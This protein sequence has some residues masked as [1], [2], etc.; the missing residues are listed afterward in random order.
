MYFAFKL[1][2]EGYRPREVLLTRE[3]LNGDVGHSM[4]S[5]F[6]KGHKSGES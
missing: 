1:D 3:M 2:K 5:L 4:N 6:R